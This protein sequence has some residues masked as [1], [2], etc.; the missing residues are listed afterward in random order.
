[1]RRA[2]L[3]E[4]GRDA[5]FLHAGEQPFPTWWTTL[6]VRSTLLTGW[7][8]GPKADRLPRGEAAL[9]KAAVDSVATLLGRAPGE[10]SEHVRRCVIADWRDDPLA[11]G[12]YSWSKVGGSLMPDALAEPIDG[13]LFMAGEHT[14]AEMIGTVAGAI[15]SGRRAARQ[16]VGDR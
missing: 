6:P 8:G 1:V 9:T 13:T 15:A 16:V 10:V 14:I 2:D 7:A 11:G 4:A 3:E 12:A 5:S